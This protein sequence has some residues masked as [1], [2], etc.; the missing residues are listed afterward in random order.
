VTT[1]NAHS[2]VEVFFQRQGWLAFE[3]TPGRFNPVAQSYA[4]PAPAKPTDGA[5]PCLTRRGADPDASCATAKPGSSAAQSPEPQPPRPASTI[6]LLPPP[7]AA[8]KRSHGWRWW[9][10]RILLLLGALFLLSLP[11]QK[12]ARR[13]LALATASGPRDRVLAAYRLMADRASDVGLRRRPHETLQEYRG[14][15]KSE[16][17]FSN[18]HVDRLTSLATLAAYSEAEVSIADADQ[19][20]AAARVAAKDISRSSGPAMRVAGWFRIERVRG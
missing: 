15:L 20:V 14:R 16:V 9:A 1:K 7:S 12:L 11:L 18:G 2:W 10:V 5:A 17:A 4:T 13:R 6:G 3:P 19:A 8:A